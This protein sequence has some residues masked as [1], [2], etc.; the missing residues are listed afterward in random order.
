MLPR[1]SRRICGGSFSASRRLIAPCSAPARAK[2]LPVCRDFARRDSD[3]PLPVLGLNLSR[4]R[5]AILLVR[6]SAALDAGDVDTS[7]RLWCKA[8]AD[9][10]TDPHVRTKHDRPTGRRRFSSEETPC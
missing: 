3:T 9:F 10:L 7:T 8:V 4:I 1:N 2:N 5:R 6:C